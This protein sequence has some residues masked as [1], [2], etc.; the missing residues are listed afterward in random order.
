[1]D[2]A[3]KFYVFVV[4]EDEYILAES[5][6]VRDVE[7][8][9]D[10][11]APLASPEDIILHKIRWFVSGGKVSDR[12]WND[13]VKVIEIQLGKLDTEYLVKWARYFEIGHLLKEA[14]D[15]AYS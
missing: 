3:F 15:Q 12:Q 5:A 2:E 1:M 11:F 4:T 8:L 9:P 6:R 7:I 13:I 10:Q 14:F